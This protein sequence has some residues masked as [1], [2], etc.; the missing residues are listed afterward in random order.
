MTMVGSTLLLPVDDRATAR[1]PAA[2]SSPDRVVVMLHG[3]PDDV[4]S[5][6]AR[7]RIDVEWARVEDR[8]SDV[9]SVEGRLAVA[10]PT[11]L[12]FM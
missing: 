5:V 11:Q 3:R 9:C 6:A 1:V 12:L 4:M 2:D 7:W 10:E 8:T